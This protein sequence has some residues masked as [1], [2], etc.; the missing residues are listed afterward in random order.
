MAITSISGPKSKF[1]VSPNFIVKNDPENP[2]TWW[3]GF[4]FQCFVFF[5]IFAFSCLSFSSFPLLLDLYIHIYICKCKLLLKVH[6]GKE[7]NFPII[8][9]CRYLVELVPRQ[10]GLPAADPPSHAHQATKCG[11]SGQDSICMR[12]WR[13]PYSI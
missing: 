8:I 10:L 12:F 1:Q 13:C 4:V 2:L 3:G 7:K 5:L 6:T 9:S 11:S